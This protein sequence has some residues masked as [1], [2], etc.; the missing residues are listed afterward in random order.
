MYF[1]PLFIF[2][3]RLIYIGDERERKWEGQRERIETEFL[4]RPKGKVDLH[5]AVRKTTT[6]AEIRSR[7]PNRL[8]H[9]GVLWFS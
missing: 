7:P 5:L 8:S 9:P 1:F 6:A 3:E 2:F 4:V